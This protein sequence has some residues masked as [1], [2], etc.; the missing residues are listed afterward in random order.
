MRKFLQLK[1]TAKA[2]PPMGD[3]QKTQSDKFKEAA[4]DLGCDRD[5]KRWEDKLRK[6]VKH[7]PVEKPE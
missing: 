3:Q 1:T 7:K 5:E 6:V 2:N 4:E